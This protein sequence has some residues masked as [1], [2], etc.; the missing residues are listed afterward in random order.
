MAVVTLLILSDFGQLKVMDLS[1]DLEQDKARLQVYNTTHKVV[2]F[3]ITAW[4]WQTGGAWKFGWS[5]E[6]LN[7][8]RTTVQ[9]EEKLKYE[10]Q[11]LLLPYFGNGK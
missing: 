6:K 7:N 2:A 3:D 11:K 10:V 1:L 4:M 8:M 5:I 9:L